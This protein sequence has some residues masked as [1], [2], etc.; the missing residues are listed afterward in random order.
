MDVRSRLV[1]T[2]E[3]IEAKVLTNGGAANPRWTRFLATTAFSVI[4]IS[5][6]VGQTFSQDWQGH[7]ARLDAA[8]AAC[9]DIYSD[10]CQPFVAQAVGIVDYMK[11][12]HSDERHCEKLNGVEVT[13]L[14]LLQDTERYFLWTQAV[15]E[16]A[17]RICKS[18]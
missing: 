1:G 15:I 14:A 3:L 5:L 11:W 17:Q 18:A 8:K 10:R 6:L 9:K 12:E 13:R 7:V 4:C 16:A 2:W